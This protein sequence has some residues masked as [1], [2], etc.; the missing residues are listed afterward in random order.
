MFRPSST[1]SSASTAVAGSASFRVESCVT[2][3]ETT[4]HQQGTDPE[5][6][7]NPSDECPPLRRQCPI[8]DQIAGKMQA[9]GDALKVK[10]MTHRVRRVDPTVA[11]C[12]DWFAAFRESRKEIKC[13][14][15]S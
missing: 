14:S 5:G 4:P 1:L 7:C 12:E 10:P 15:S 3:I 9:M 11:Q 2:D 6:G 8:V 13:T